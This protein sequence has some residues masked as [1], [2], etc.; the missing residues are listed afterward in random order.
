LIEVCRELT[1]L[2]DKDNDAAVTTQ[3]CFAEV[4]GALKEA[5][6]FSQS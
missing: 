2:N 6:R 5:A 3:A 4:I 1:T